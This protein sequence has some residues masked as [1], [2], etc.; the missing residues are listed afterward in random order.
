MPWAKFLRPLTRASSTIPFYPNNAELL[1]ELI[2]TIREPEV[3][4]YLVE[5]LYLSALF[6]YVSRCV[7]KRKQAAADVGDVFG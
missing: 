3:D 4:Q 6:L 5:P 2:A 1:G 7:R